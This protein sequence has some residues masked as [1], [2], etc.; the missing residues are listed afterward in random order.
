[1]NE[2]GEFY[3][4]NHLLVLIAVVVLLGLYIRSIKNRKRD[5]IPKQSKTEEDNKIKESPI[6]ES[7]FYSASLPIELIP[8]DSED[9]LQILLKTKEAEIITYY[10]NGTKD[11]KIW[12]A[13]KM[14]AESNV[15]HNL[16]SRPE[17]RNPNWQKA[18]IIKV[19]VEVNEINKEETA[20]QNAPMKT[21]TNQGRLDGEHLSVSYFILDE[22]WFGQNKIITV[23]F[24]DGNY[25]GKIFKYN[26]DEVYVGTIQ[27]YQ[28]KD[29][30]NDY[31]RF[32]NS[33][34]IPEIC[35]PFVSE[36][37]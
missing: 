29:S 21:K 4:S 10:Q 27:H 36:I 19:V 5:V 15:I 28:T 2:I 18:N 23:T 7:S 14:T 25:K 32:S 11:S 33:S 22:N 8:N 34:N 6:S 17:F 31:G 13:S 9:F 3:E 37:I 24:V 20:I 1:M 26:H 30:W 16:R 12:N 35:K